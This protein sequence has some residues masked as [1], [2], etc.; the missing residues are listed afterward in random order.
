MARAAKILALVLGL[1]ALAAGAVVWR[2]THTPYGT[3]DL[4]A[5]VV[6]HAMPDG[7]LEPSPERR[8]EANAMVAR[9]MR[10]EPDPAIEIR[11]LAFPGP[12]G[13]LPLRVYVPPGPGPFPVVVWIHGG[14][15]WM[16][17]EL[18]LW[19]GACTALARDVPAVVASLGY[20][21]APEHPFPVA[22]EDSWAGLRFVAAEASGWSGDPERIAV[23]GGSAGGNLAAVMAQ[24]AREEGGP[25]LAYQVLIVPATRADGQSTESRRMFW[26]GYGLDGIGEMIAA[27]LPDPAQRANPWAAPLLAERFDG[28]PPALILTAEFDPLRDEGEE[29]G[30]KLRAAGVPVVV[31]RYEGAIHGFL[32]S[33]EAAADAHRL[34]V[35]HLRAAFGVDGAA[36][37]GGG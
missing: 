36:P 29:Y 9:F 27:Y 13:E 11:E 8:V 19:D 16:G 34:S 3:M 20:R 32:G 37:I 10:S 31:K 33:P 2:W 15:F 4:G 17:D 7:T 21:L 28:L 22:V 23:M 26:T 12:A 6:A 24:R 30:E 25:G 5:A 35:E 14:G 1:L 18:P